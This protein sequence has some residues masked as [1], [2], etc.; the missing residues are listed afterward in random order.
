MFSKL[1]AVKKNRLGPV[2]VHTK[3]THMFSS[4]KTSKHPIRVYFRKLFRE[5]FSNLDSKGFKFKRTPCL[6]RETYSKH[7]GIWGTL[8]IF[9]VNFSK[10]YSQDFNFG[11]L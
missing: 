4:R 8:E 2:S 3:S 9:C 10:K 6:V 7:Q 11:Y 1:R 5:S